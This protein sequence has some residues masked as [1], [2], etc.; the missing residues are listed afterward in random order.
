[1][2]IFLEKYATDR[3][4]GAALYSAFLCKQFVSETAKLTPSTEPNLMIRPGCASCHAT[5][6]PLAAYFTRIEPSSF[7]FLPEAQFPI[8]NG[9]CK[10]DAKG[11]LSGACNAFYDVAFVDGEGAMLRS[12]YGSPKHADE[13]AAGA[14]RDIVAMPEFAS[15]AVER[16]ASSLLGRPTAEEDAAFLAS[17]TAKFVSSGFRMKPLVAAVLRSEAYRRAHELGEA[18]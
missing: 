2:P 17:L 18:R 9:K 11:N 4:R 5:L 13:G 7:T 16:V 15:C 6:E 14:G 10:K 1:M 3:A 8:R 12:A